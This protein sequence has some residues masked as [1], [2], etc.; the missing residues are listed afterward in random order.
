MKKLLTFTL[1]VMVV[2]FIGY[3]S[4]TKSEF[5]S[6]LVLQNIEALASGEGSGNPLKCWRTISDD[7]P[8]TQTHV[9]YCG[10]CDA[11][12]ARTWYRESQCQN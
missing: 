1:F 7:G 8:N 5:T 6:D 10:S 4:N 3:S 11:I 12:L 9:T 2:F